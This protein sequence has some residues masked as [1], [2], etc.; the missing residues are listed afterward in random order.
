MRQKAYSLSMSTMRWGWETA[1]GGIAMA[2]D[3]KVEER[4]VVL[5]ELCGFL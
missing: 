4:E 1:G 2:G 5:C 3:Q